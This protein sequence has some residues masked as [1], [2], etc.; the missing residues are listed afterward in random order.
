MNSAMHKARVAWGETMPDWIRE[1]AQACDEEGLRQ[2]SARIGVSPA[3]TSLAVNKKRDALEFIKRKVE[4]SLM[5]AMMPC[6][7]LGVI[8][9]AECLQEQAKPFT[10]ANPLSVQLFRACRSGCR[11]YKKL[12]KQSQTK[13][14]H[15]A[16]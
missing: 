4:G 7:V 11:Y 13:G 14:A 8:S 10:A 6:P 1:L 9:R 2:V 5:I 12:K 15:H 16:V 3:M